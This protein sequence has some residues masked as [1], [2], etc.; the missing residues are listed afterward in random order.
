[1]ILRLCRH[2]NSLPQSLRFI[3]AG[4]VAAAINWLVRFPLSALM[5][6]VPAVLLAS[7]IGMLVGFITYRTFVF[8]G[9][10][11]PMHAQIRD[12]V[13]INISSFFAVAASAMLIRGVLVSSMSL[14]PAEA[15]AHGVAIGIGAAL[16]YFGHNS[17]TFK[18]RKTI[19]T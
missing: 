2:A 10:K 4:G 5:A 7:A 16:N 11:R 3:L 19:E 8:P 12:F 18:N 14:G 1:M 17:L 9:S 15:L 6:F 13:I